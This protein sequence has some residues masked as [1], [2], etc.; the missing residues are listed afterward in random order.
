MVT[1]VLSCVEVLFEMLLHHT[2]G[3]LSSTNRGTFR[4]SDMLQPSPS[5]A[6]LPSAWRALQDSPLA[7]G[8]PRLGGGGGVC[9]SRLQGELR[10]E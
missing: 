5:A 8:I 9:R 3:S 4:R 6:C 1:G 2:R 10:V 7:G